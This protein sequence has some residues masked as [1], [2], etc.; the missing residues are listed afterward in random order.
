MG[1]FGPDSSEYP[2]PLISVL[3]RCGLACR[4]T[5]WSPG[6]PP[7]IITKIVFFFETLSGQNF[8]GH[9]F[10][11]SLPLILV[12]T[13]AGILTLSP[14]KSSIILRFNAEM[15]SFLHLENIMGVSWTRRKFFL[16]SYKITARSATRVDMPLMP[17]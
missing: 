1:C 12:R 16:S 2:S 8:P 14:G 4:A 10:G 3:V 11:A 6:G 7:E 17:L 15:Q 13:L 5:G 9:N